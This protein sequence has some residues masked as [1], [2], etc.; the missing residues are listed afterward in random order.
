MGKLWS[1]LD[2]VVNRR[3]TGH[4]PPHAA[5]RR[6]VQTFRASFTSGC[7]KLLGSLKCGVTVSWTMKN[8]IYVFIQYYCER[9]FA[10]APVLSER[11]Y[12][13]FD[14]MICPCPTLGSHP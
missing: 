4:L 11:V 2:R 8:T 12:P 3:N 9:N 6:F 14:L 5:K 7:G 1:W 13:R 10:D